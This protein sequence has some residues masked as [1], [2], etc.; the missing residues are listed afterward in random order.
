MSDSEV[1]AHNPPPYAAHVTTIYNKGYSEQYATYYIRPWARKHQT[2]AVN[3]E[4]ILAALRVVQPKWLDIA[5]G[6][7]W[8]FRG[9]FTRQAM[10]FGLD[11]SIPQLERAKLETPTAHFICADMAQ[12][13]FLAASF[14]LVTNFWAGYCYL[15]DSNRI[16]RLI[17]DGL[18]WIRPGGALYMEVLL[19]KDLASFNRSRFS[20]T[21]TFSVIPRS[22]DFTEW[23]YDDIGGRH[24]MISPPLLFF[25]DILAPHF[26][27]I[28]AVHDGSFMVH[29]VATSRK[30]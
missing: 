24:E 9:G 16:D 2:N 11:L 23:Y 5:C 10:M 28:E 8:H 30:S 29:L 7:A 26:E 21:T 17:R 4:R 20:A 27:E 25:V 12:A 19:P 22:T 18:S 3:L 13:P 14:D 15:N 1:G 6:P